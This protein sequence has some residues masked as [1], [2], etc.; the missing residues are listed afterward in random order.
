MILKFRPGSLPEFAY[1]SLRGPSAQRASRVARNLGNGFVGPSFLHL[2]HSDLRHA[3]ALQKAR[4]SPKAR[5]RPRPYFRS[6]QSESFRPIRTLIEEHLR[7]GL[8]SHELVADLATIDFGPI[9]GVG[10]APEFII[11]GLLDDSRGDG[12][13][14]LEK[15]LVN[16]RNAIPQAVRDDRKQR[17][18]LMLNLAEYAGDRKRIAS[19]HKIEDGDIARK[20]AQSCIGGMRN[21]WD[22]LA[23]D[24]WHRTA[25]SFRLQFSRD[26]SDL[27]LAYM[28]L[29]KV[30]DDLVFGRIPA[31]SFNNSAIPFHNLLRTLKSELTTKRD[32]S[33]FVAN[34]FNSCKEIARQEREYQRKKCWPVNFR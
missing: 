30:S 16:L 20:L 9:F 15:V 19:F 7:Q 21:M 11:H 13:E 6:Q 18:Q 17:C 2:C 22:H 27:W 3:A 8:V 29:M 5:A 10:V 28:D 24:A 26:L 1:D 31:A 25:R 12:I 34:V 23:S 14:L 32:I 33:L 4:L